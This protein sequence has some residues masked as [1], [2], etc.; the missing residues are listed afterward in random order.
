MYDFADNGGLIVMMKSDEPT[1]TLRFSS[2][3]GHTW[4]ECDI[5]IGGA[6]ERV[7]VFFVGLLVCSSELNG[8]P[9]VLLVISL[10]QFCVQMDGKWT[11]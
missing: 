8:S 1:T 6:A 10:L 7:C 4:R 9:H 5:G 11:C 2:D 3:G